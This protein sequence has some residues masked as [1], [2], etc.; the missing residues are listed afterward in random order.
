MGN[1]LTQTGFFLINLIFTF[2]ITLVLLRFL[3]Q[4][5]KA[6]F[7]NPICQ[8]IVKLTNPLL[9][10]LRRLIPGW[11]GLDLA[12]VFLIIAL[13]AV[14]LILIGLLGSI[15]LNAGI[16]IAIIFRLVMLVLNTYFFAVILNAI[17][18]WVNPNPRHPLTMLLTQLT[19]PLLRPIRRILPT[20]SG[21]DL[22]PMVVIIVLMVIRIFLQN[23]VG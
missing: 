3:L 11:F 12:A 16:I 23:L 9:V 22:S 14:E 2:Y 19:E 17:L 7:Y 5:V 15:P 1:A 10:P 20:M 18:S 21:I 4:I 6:D 13:Q 8:F